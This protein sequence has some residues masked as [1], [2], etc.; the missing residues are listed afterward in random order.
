MQTQFQVR[1]SSITHSGKL[2][3][4]V[5][6]GGG[7]LAEAEHRARSTQEEPGGY[8]YIVKLIASVKRLVPSVSLGI[9]CLGLPEQ[10]LAHLTK[11][12]LPLQAPDRETAS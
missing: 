12:S 9:T 1:S 5:K 11:A 6:H 2:C 4:A 3:Y 8:T 7:G 10:A